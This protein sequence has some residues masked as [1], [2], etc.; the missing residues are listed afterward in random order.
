[1]R[2]PAF[3]F[4]LL[5]CLEWMLAAELMLRLL[6]FGMPV[7][8]VFHPTAQ[9]APAPSQFT[10]RLG[11]IIYTNAFGMRSEEPDTSKLRILK[12]G[13]SI[14]NGGSYVGNTSLSSYRLQDSLSA[15]CGV[16]VLNISS[17]SWGPDNAEAFL[18]DFGDFG[19]RY[20]VLVFSSHDATDTVEAYSPVGVQ[21]DFPVEHYALALQELGWRYILKVPQKNRQMGVV[22]KENY[23]GAMLNPGFEK[24]IAYLRERNIPV[25]LYLHPTLQELEQGELG[26]GGRAILEKMESLSVPCIAGL[27]FMKSSGYRDGIHLNAEG[28]IMLTSG[29]M[30]LLRKHGWLK[31]ICSADV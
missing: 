25:V 17:G 1:M 27:P 29:V 5:G 7:R 6:G 4:I 28:Q 24:L 30:F 16:Q 18:R 9:Y 21:A 8:Y 20:A 3:V 11:N 15:S 14:L 31:Q 12:V 22:Q 10:I 19:A 26:V 13:D 2:Y 23:H